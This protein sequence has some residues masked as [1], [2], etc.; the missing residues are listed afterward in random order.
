MLRTRSYA[1][2]SCE[3]L[4]GTCCRLFLSCINLSNI[5]VF[6]HTDLMSSS[7]I[8]SPFHLSQAW[9]Q[10]WNTVKS[11]WLPCWRS[12]PH[13]SGPVWGKVLWANH[14]VTRAWTPDRTVWLCSTAPRWPPAGSTGMLLETIISNRGLIVKQNWN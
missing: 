7:G 13:G 6:V 4:M 1:I 12:W 9:K 14:S 10:F 8:S 2:Q 3:N 5:K 11:Y